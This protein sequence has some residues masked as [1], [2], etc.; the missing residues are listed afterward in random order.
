[1]AEKRVAQVNELIAHELGLII[2]RE[3]E[4]PLGSLLTI[5]RVSTDAELKHTL[6][7]VSVIPESSSEEVLGILTRERRNLQH[8]LNRRLAMQFIPSL[9]FKKM[10]K[11][12]EKELQEEVEFEHLLDNIAKD[13]EKD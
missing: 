8:L 10:T 13:L 2:A 4:F 7:L 5:V 1:M 6:V 3:L 11:E 12:E 9:H